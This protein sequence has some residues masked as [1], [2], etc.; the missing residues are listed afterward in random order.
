MQY[1]ISNC[2]SRNI[3]M[4]FPKSRKREQNF[5]KWWAQNFC[6]SSFCLW[7]QFFAKFSL[8]LNLEMEIQMKKRSIDF[9][10]WKR[11]TIN[12]NMHFYL[13]VRQF[14]IYNGL[15]SRAPGFQF[16]LGS[17]KEITDSDSC[18][19]G[20]IALS[21]KKN[22]TFTSFLFLSEFSLRREKIRASGVRVVGVVSGM[23]LLLLIL[24]LSDV[25]EMFY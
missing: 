25:S 6:V 13:V 18:P 3:D 16:L 17:L 20:S 8:L 4:I 10:I 23:G 21:L 11:E 9:E 12:T 19:F 15:S 7:P 24:K 5:Q 1:Y 22:F 2:L 14:I